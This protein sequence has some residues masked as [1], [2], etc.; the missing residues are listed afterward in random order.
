MYAAPLPVFGD[1]S[2]STA[3]IIA[4]KPSAERATEEPKKSFDAR[5][6]AR[7]FCCCDHTLD[8]LVNK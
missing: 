3:P 5:S 8:V 7:I 4:V 6:E 2:L 1:V